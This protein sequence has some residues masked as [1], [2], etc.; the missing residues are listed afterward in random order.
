MISKLERSSGKVIG[1]VTED[2]IDLAQFEALLPEVE[3]LI[4]EHGRIN[5]LFHIKSMKGYGVKEFAADVKFTVKHWNDIGKVAIVSDKDWW[6]VAARIDNLFTKWEERYFD[7][8]ELDKAWAWVE[9]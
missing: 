6:G 8:S 1:F 7:S 9:K 5:L 2:K 3:A 4:T